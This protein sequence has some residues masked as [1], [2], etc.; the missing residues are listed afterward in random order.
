MRGSGVWVRLVV[1]VHQLPD[2]SVRIFLRGGQGLVTEKLL[3]GAK[4]GAVGEKMRSKRVAK[5]VRMEIPVYV[6][7]ADVFLD[8]AADGTLR[9]TPPGVI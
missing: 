3:D 1:N 2:R 7:E 5:R 4:V 8:D 6:H 9:E